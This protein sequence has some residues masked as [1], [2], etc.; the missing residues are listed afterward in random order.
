MERRLA[1]K[2]RQG[3]RSL[4]RRSTHSVRVHERRIGPEP[5]EEGL[6]ALRGVDGLEGRQLRQELLHRS[7]GG[8]LP[9]TVDLTEVTHLASAGVSV[10]H[11]VAERHAAQGGRLVLEAEPDCPACHVLTLVAIPGV[12][13]GAPAE[14]PT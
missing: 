5:L 9:L 14:Q 13:V 7:R 10:L 12:A 3:C 4:E 11:H 6:E 1:S 8:T 2:N